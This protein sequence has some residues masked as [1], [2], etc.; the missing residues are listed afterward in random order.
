MCVFWLHLSDLFL[1]ITALSQFGFLRIGD[2]ERHPGFRLLM[3]RHRGFESALRMIFDFGPV[4]QIGEDTW[5]LPVY[6]PQEWLYRL[7]YLDQFV[8]VC[9]ILDFSIYF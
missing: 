9:L 4:G 7:S 6:I 5:L 8:Y 2:N 1:T 3:R